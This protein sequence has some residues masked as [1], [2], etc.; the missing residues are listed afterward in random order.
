MVALH[1]RIIVLKKFHYLGYMSLCMLKSKCKMHLTQIRSVCL[2]FRA[3]HCSMDMYC[4]WFASSL[5]NKEIFPILFFFAKWY[6]Q[7]F[8]LY[9]LSSSIIS[10]FPA[11]VIYA[12]PL[13]LGWI[14]FLYWTQLFD[15]RN[16][17]LWC[18]FYWLW[19][20]KEDKEG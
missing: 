15:V 12:S 18:I 7:F 9:N 1:V 16:T 19:T 10:Y 8:A 13:N 2:K 3:N 14:R 17:T 6:S 20:L 5:P 11:R 4:L